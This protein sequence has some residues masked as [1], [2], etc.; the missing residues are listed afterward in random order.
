ME[1]F[2]IW[3]LLKAALSATEPPSANTQ[4]S[5]GAATNPSDEAPFRQADEGAET[6]TMHANFPP[7]ANACEEYFL[8]HE[9]L[10]NHRKK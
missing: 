7:R 4:I 5:E 3:N 8:R 2:A 1:P 10:K 9:Q 6:T